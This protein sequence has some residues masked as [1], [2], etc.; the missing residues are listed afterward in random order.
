MAAGVIIFILSSCGQIKELDDNQAYI[1]NSTAEN[2]DGTDKI[3]EIQNDSTVNSAHTDLAEEPKEER[4]SIPY[5]VDLYESKGLDDVANESLDFRNEE[6]NNS[7]IKN[8]DELEILI[9]EYNYL[10]DYGTGKL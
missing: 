2:C 1:M 9:G 7:Q 5:E 3:Q 4:R 6:K 8:D 10:S